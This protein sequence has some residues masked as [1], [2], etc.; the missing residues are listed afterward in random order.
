MST[1]G[2]VCDEMN[3]NS[4]GTEVFCLLDPGHDDDHDCGE[5][6]WPRED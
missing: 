3:H 5:F 2:P 6:T 4:V 1:T